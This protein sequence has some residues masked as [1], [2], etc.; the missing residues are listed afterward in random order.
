VVLHP[1]L[2]S[3]A[4]P[5]CSL[6]LSLHAEF[7]LHAAT[8][9]ISFGP[10]QFWPSPNGWAGSGPAPI[11]LKK[12]SKNFKNHFKKKVIFSNIFLPILH[13]IGLYIYI[14]KYNSGI[15]IS[16]FLRNISKKN[17]ISKHFKKEK[18]ISL[19]TSKS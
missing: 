10:G 9:I 18:N 17:K 2:A 5:C 14:V 3:T 6:L 7:I 19:H 13:N 12:N 15:K 4:R 11:F 16:D 1:C 8:K